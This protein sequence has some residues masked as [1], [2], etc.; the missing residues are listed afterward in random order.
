V[1]T[2]EQLDRFLR[3]APAADQQVRAAVQRHRKAGVR[4]FAFLLDGCQNDGAALVIQPARVYATLTGGVGVECFVAERYLA[5]F[6]VSAA[7]VSGRA[8][9]G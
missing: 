4:L 8:R 7:T 9:I 3:G 6:A 2:P 1:T 5:V